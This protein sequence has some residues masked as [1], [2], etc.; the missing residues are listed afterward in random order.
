MRQLLLAT[1]YMK[2]MYTVYMFQR[3]LMNHYKNV[4]KS[5]CVKCHTTR[6]LTN[7]PIKKCRNVTLTCILLHA[8]ICE[9]ACYAHLHVCCFVLCFSVSPFLMFPPL[10]VSLSVYKCTAFFEVCLVFLCLALST[11]SCLPM[12]RYCRCHLCVHGNSRHPNVIYVIVSSIC[13][14]MTGKLG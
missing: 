6:S 9:L 10:I 8:S 14:I 7:L 4:L 11:C 13:R 2:P 12:S 3:L 5:A 1:I